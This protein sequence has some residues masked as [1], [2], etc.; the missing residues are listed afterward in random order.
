MSIMIST[1]SR[2]QRSD[3]G[4]LPS[5]VALFVP[6]HLGC[7]LRRLLR[8]FALIVRHR[9][10]PGAHPHRG[11]TMRINRTSRS[12]APRHLDARRFLRPA[13]R[14][15]WHLGASSVTSMPLE[16]S[17]ACAD[18]LGADDR[19]GVVEH[20]RAVHDSLAVPALHQLQ[21]DLEEKQQLNYTVAPC[22]HQF[23]HQH[24]HISVDEVNTAHGLTRSS[25]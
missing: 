14:R 8:M 5:A 17:G 21:V 11:V 4:P 2:R 23:S 25:R 18:D 13:R 1:A 24:P 16:R 6:G 7:P 22:L 10:A 19:L 20:Q 12:S 3:F 15:S 9:S